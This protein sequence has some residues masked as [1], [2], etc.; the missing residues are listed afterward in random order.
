MRQ[1]IFTSMTTRISRRDF[2]KLGGFASLSTFVWGCAPQAVSSA[3][4]LPTTLPSTEADSFLFNALKR[5]TFGPTLEDLELARQIGFEA[6]VEQQLAYEALDDSQL[7]PRLSHL[8]TLEMSPAEIAVVEKQSLPVTELVQSTLLRAAYSR[9][10]LYE[11][12][13]NFWSDHFNIYI[14][15]SQDRIL[16]TADDREVIRPNALGNF[17]ALL[18]ASMHSPAMLVYL[19]NASSTRDG[20]NENYA[21]ELLEL[22]TLG[23]SGGYSQTDVQEVARALTGW[24]VTGRRGGEGAGAFIFKGTFH[25]DGAK[26]ILG[27]EFPAGQGIEEGDRLIT[28]LAEHPSTADFISYKLARH[29]VADDPPA[30][31]V[32]KTSAVFG[33]SH[34]DIREV[35]RTILFSDEF[36]QSLGS[37]KLKKPIEFVISTIRQLNI[38]SE[39]NRPMNGMLRS[40]GHIPFFWPAPN[41]YP[42]IGSA[43][44]N[45]NDLL[46]RW[47]F[48]LA[49]AS[50]SLKDS[51]VDWSA[52]VSS[53]AS[54]EEIIDAMS[55]RLIGSTLPDEPRGRLLEALSG[56]S[57]V[58]PALAVGSL[59]I[60]SPYFQYR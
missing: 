36:R 54:M 44:L 18:S 52:L 3:V 9:R 46:T 30:S 48:A 40:M 11:R 2:L 51:S 26:T 32:A 8:T 1:D 13:V 4:A 55:A 45:S 42:D 58:D 59:L 17:H 39:F 37:G 60:A 23:V 34:G 47:N 28:L 16:K 15:K 35:L 49:I 19:D 33:S 56:L 22:H 25:D 7:V 20:P 53:S 21:R 38:E 50:N 41:G 14:L 31:L 10:Q 57:D 43:W 12:M 29:F 5:I 24:S 27:V 6:F